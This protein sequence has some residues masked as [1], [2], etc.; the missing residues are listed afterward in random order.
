MR[1]LQQQL[2]PH[3]LLVHA[4]VLGLLYAAGA[5][6][7][8]RTWPDAI[9]DFGHELYIP[10]RIAAGDAPYRDIFLVTG[11]AS[12]LF[13]AGLFA[14]C[15]TS[16]TTLIVSN[17]I[18]LAA[19]VALL[20]DGL[21]A[22]S[23]RWVALTG[24]AVFLLVFAYGDYSQIGNYNYVCPY[25]HEMT[26]GLLA[27]LL[28]LACLR[29][30]ESSGRPIWHALA[31]AAYGVSLL[32]K[33]EVALPALGGIGLWQLLGGTAGKV[34]RSGLV[35]FLGGLTAPLI[36]CLAVL[37]ARLSWMEAVHGLVAAW[38]FMF[39]PE[40]TQQATF[41]RALAGWNAPLANGLEVLLSTLAI[42][43]GLLLAIMFDS[44]A[45]ERAQRASL[46]VVLTVA[47]MLGGLWIPDGVWY[48]AARALPVLPIWLVST[49]VLRRW[50]VGP[51]SPEA[52]W[53]GAWAGF[54]GLFTLK[55][56]L[57]CTW[58]HYGFVLAAPALL[59]AIR[60]LLVSV[61][62]AAISRRG[63]GTM[64]CSVCLGLIAAFALGQF[65]RTLRVASINTV[66]IASG[67][68][69]FY[70]PDERFDARPPVVRAT[71]EHLQARMASEQ[72]LL[73]IHDGTLLNYL[74]RRRNPTPYVLLSPWDVAAAGGEERVLAEL[75]RHPPDWLVLQGDDMSPHGTGPFGSPD[76]GPRL[77]AWVVEHYRLD[78]SFA[79]G[80]PT[81]PS[82]YRMRILTR[83]LPAVTVRPPMSE[84]IDFRARS[85][86]GVGTLTS[87]ATRTGCRNSDE[88]RYSEPICS[89]G[90]LRFGL[91]GGSA[92]SGSA[93]W[94]G[95]GQT[96]RVNW[97]N[98]AGGRSMLR[99]ITM[100]GSLMA[101]GGRSFIIIGGRLLGSGDKEPPGHQKVA[102]GV[103]FTMVNARFR[104]FHLNSQ[105]PLDNCQRVGKLH[106]TDNIDQRRA[107]L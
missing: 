106:L 7:T 60:W 82:G 64:V 32:L 28:S 42:G 88:F 55:M 79:A 41:Y 30:G 44:V 59:L 13:H 56:L 66:P 102:A 38:S 22:C 40:L 12:Q 46:R 65:S 100:P 107:G 95:R 85:R 39:R 72:T 16:L 104:E 81:G 80:D 45:G 89:S 36:L 31:G 99:W 57:R 71:L 61:P 69:R 52:R 101:R 3:N 63:N 84:A 34:R 8:W 58:A 27:G 18:V 92:G 103:Q 62:A 48:Q 25:R 14:L 19:I 43:G 24:S 78:T 11:P 54:A 17:L 37:K 76:Y 15:G 20:Y 87:S 49:A 98:V 91:R 67:G 83:K 68:D 53:V 21:A 47:V 51:L 73:V 96:E 50:A 74:L 93:V 4:F 90:R 23:P 70:V 26:H 77:A 94:T 6:V 86:L 5:A 105:N 35:W 10:W 1:H 75:V 33:V 97:E 9:V 2:D 29:R